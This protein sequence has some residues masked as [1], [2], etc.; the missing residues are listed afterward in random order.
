MERRIVTQAGLSDVVC[1]DCWL[2]GRFRLLHY[3]RVG[4]RLIKRGLRPYRGPDSSIHSKAEYEKR[5]LSISG[6]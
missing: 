1:L 6:Y 5:S 3:K 2:G 4:A